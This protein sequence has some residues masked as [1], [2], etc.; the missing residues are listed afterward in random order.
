M[1]PFHDHHTK[2]A[3]FNAALARYEDSRVYKLIGPLVSVANLAL[4]V[5]VVYLVWPLSLGW[6]GQVLALA[7]AYLVA[8]FI[9][10][11]THMIVDN[12]DRYD[13]AAGPLI[14][15]FHLHH[16]TPVYR[17][18]PLPVVY[19]NENGS[20]LWLVAFLGGA[21]I[22]IGAA[23][24]PP[25]AAYFLVYVGILSSVAEVSHYLCH[26]SESRLA[27]V[28]QKVGLLLSK[29]HH[30]R[31]HTQD[32]VNYAFLNGMTDPLLNR[33]AHRL[34][35]GYKDTTDQ[36]YATYTGAGTKNRG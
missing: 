15:A 20:K 12:N 5:L 17:R 23:M 22:L 24:L 18:N 34:Y 13:T 26:T 10:G 27:R 14:A 4:Q 7:L 35:S 30:A 9:N 36:H 33:I 6:A 3:Q 19:F 11:L 8:D 2:Q 28:L 25:F 31:H 21:A 32:N 1:N 16:R 29:R